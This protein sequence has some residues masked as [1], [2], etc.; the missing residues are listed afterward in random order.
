MRAGGTYAIAPAIPLRHMRGSN[1]DRTRGRKRGSNSRDSARNTKMNTVKYYNFF[2]RLMQ[3][4]VPRPLLQGSIIHLL[5]E[6]LYIT[7]LNHQT[8]NQLNEAKS[9]C[10][11]LRNWQRGRE[12]KLRSGCDVL[13]I[14]IPTLFRQKINFETDDEG[15]TV[16]YLGQIIADSRSNGSEGTSL[17]HQFRHFGNEDRVT[18]YYPDY[19]SRGRSLSSNWSDLPTWSP[20]LVKSWAPPLTMCFNEG[21]WPFYP[22]MARRASGSPPKLIGNLIS[23]LLVLI[24][25]NSIQII[26]LEI[27]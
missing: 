1:E 8:T 25:G 26:V 6:Y 4:E 19:F 2:K 21:A 15:H 3:K 24:L 10:S 12:Q 16:L 27:G 5:M 13:G 7:P 18:H 9:G 20:S 17:F 23:L 11:A 22:T 14:K